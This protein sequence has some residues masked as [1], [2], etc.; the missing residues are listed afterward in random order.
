M[1]PEAVYQTNI[2][3]LDFLFSGKVRDIYDLVEYLLIVTTDRISAFDMI[4]PTPIPGKGEVLNQISLFWM[5]RFSGLVKNHLADLSLNQVIDDP[6]VCALLQDRAVVVKKAQPLPVE[7]VVRGYLIG[8]GWNDYQKSGKVCGIALPKGLKMAQKLPEPIF[9]PATKASAGEHDENIPFDDVTKLIGSELAQKIKTI[10][11][12]LYEEASS[13][14]M[15]KGIIIAD[16][17]FEFGLVG[18]ELVLIDEVLTPDS[19]RFWPVA[20]YEVGV[21]PVSYDKQ[22][23][24]DYLISLNWDKS[25]PAP[26]LPPEVVQKTAEKYR[27]IAKIFLSPGS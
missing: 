12:K 13:F 9:T 3:G 7:C 16:T 14:A 24:R 2:K 4:L 20:Q 22:F 18:D 8:S 27:E 17:K 25:P 23:V 19:S 11:L 5:K 1:S 21:S 10:S 15:G 6:D 26:V